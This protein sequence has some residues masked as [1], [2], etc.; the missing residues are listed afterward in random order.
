MS[1]SSYFNYTNTFLNQATMTSKKKISS[2]F[3]T[4]V[5][6]VP[7]S[8]MDGMATKNQSSSSSS[9]IPVID[10]GQ[11]GPTPSISPVVPSGAPFHNDTTSLS[12]NKGKQ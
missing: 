9:D 7:V 4:D 5:S 6:P 11:T 12:E 10:L 1:T 3:T 2:T 8:T